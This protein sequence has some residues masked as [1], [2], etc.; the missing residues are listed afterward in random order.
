MC[1]NAMIAKIKTIIKDPT[2]AG[3]FIVTVGVFLG[4]IFSYL[5]QIGLGH[6]LS[7]EDFGLFNA[8]LSL[9]II[10]GIPASAISVSLIKKV[11]QLLAVQNFYTLRKLYWSFT[12]IALVLGL[13]ISAIFVVLNTLVA[14]YL[15]IPHGT[16]IYIFAVFLAFSFINVVP[17][18]YLQGLLRFK[19]FAFLSLVSQFLRL[20]IPLGLVYAG[21]AVTG[22]YTGLT[23]V[24]LLTFFVALLLLAK[25]FN[26]GKTPVGDEAQESSIP[27]VYK[28]LLIFSL[29]VL[30]I[31]LGINLLNNTDI[32][33]V[34]H[35]FSPYEAGVY[36]GVVTMCKVYL[37]GAS[38]V[39]VVMFPQ[40]SHL[41]ALGENYKS[42]FLKF[43]MLQLLLTFGGLGIFTVFPSPINNLMFGGKFVDSV[44]YLPLFALFVAL[45]ILI[46]FLSM[47]LL[48]ISKTKAFLVILPTCVLQYILI[49]TFHTNLFS[50][51]KANIL[52]TGLACLFIIIYVIKSLS[53]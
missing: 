21:F 13:A 34:K 37:F 47:F 44:T 51:I 32:V 26:Q 35:F 6:L 14:N 48:A 29:P 3:T 28:Q 53:R 9:S 22:A 4:S 24:G 33:M 49:S 38:I 15:N 10:F 19:A 45:Y 5:L 12:K 46:T 18:A 27:V 8:F 2:L 52:S 39:Q 20:I 30:F 11:S 43:L 25:N 16:V 40:I 42:R 50:V 41:H 1:I 36:A 23:L 7:I 17:M 31:N